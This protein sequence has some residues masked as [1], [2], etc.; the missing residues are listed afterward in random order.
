VLGKLVV[1]QKVEHAMSGNSQIIQSLCSSLFSDLPDIQL[2]ILLVVIGILIP[3]S[4]CSQFTGSS[5]RAINIQYSRKHGK[6]DHGACDTVECYPSRM[7]SNLHYP[8]CQQ[9][10]PNQFDMEMG[11]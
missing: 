2:F 6:Y 10:A 8:T 7:L 3:P 9:L 11:K 1:E 5:P 4:I